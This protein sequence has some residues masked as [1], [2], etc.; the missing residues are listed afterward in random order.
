[1]TACFYIT[2]QILR[3]LTD[4]NR[5]FQSHEKTCFIIFYSTAEPVGLLTNS[6]LEKAFSKY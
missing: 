1:M 3:P 2:S 6:N 4:V 5:Q